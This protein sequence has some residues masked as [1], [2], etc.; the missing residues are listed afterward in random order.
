MN[1]IEIK[2]EKLE[3]LMEMIL[4]KIDGSHDKKA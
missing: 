2:L 4:S 1:R 3:V